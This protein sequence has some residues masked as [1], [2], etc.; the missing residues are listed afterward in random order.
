VVG[1]ALE[2]QLGLLLVAWFVLQSLLW[3]RARLGM[4]LVR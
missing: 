1:N 4:A 2:W 3:K